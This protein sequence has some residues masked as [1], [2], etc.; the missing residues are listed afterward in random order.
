MECSTE[1]GLL[2]P[3]LEKGFDGMQEAL[4]TLFNLAMKIERERH[5]HAG[6]YQRTAE[7]ADYAN[8]YK[9][10][11][12]QT[13]EGEFNLSIPQTRNTDFYPS[14]LE[15]GLRSERALRIAIAEMYIHGVA[16]RKV[17]D[18]LEKTCGL[19]VTAMQVSRAAQMLDQEFEKWRNRSL[20]EPVK[21]LLLDARYEKVR[22]DGAVV[23]SALLIAY[24]VM[25]DGHRR[26]LGVSVEMSEAE[27]HWRHFLESLVERGLHGLKMITSDNHPGLKNARKSVS[28]RFHGSAVSSIC[29]RMRPRMCRRNPCRAKSTTTSGTFSICPQKQKPKSCSNEPLTNIKTSFSNS[30]NGLKTIFRKALP[31]LLLSSR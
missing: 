3:I 6:L 1:Q 15:R 4:Q 22:T 16:T 18:I 28:P 14:C 21:Y 24:S 17:R 29:S 9:P 8:G 20:K 7:R 10:R 12:I 23:D 2:Q 19:E 11:T 25:E 30:R 5:L 13:L 26:V 27:A 31:Y